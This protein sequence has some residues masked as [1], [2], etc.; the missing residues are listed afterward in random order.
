YEIDPD[1]VRPLLPAGTE[2]DFWNGRTYVSVVGF[3][4]IDTKLR[5]FPIP[6][7]RNFNEVNLRFY[8]R[9][10]TAGEWRRGVVFIKEIV[11]LPAV[12]FVARTVYNENY[13]TLPMQHQLQLPGTNGD[14][15]GSFAYSWK[16]KQQWVE[17]AVETMGDSQPSVP[18]SEEEFITEHY[19]GYTRQR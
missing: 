6:F 10:Q 9:R 11:P 16:W 13:V 1:I 17:L 15:R 2:L 5:G 12:T 8:V 19:W 14:H 7:H 4:F 3:R 18:G